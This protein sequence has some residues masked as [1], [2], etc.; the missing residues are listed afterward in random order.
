MI[1]DIFKRKKRTRFIPLP[2]DAQGTRMTM[3]VNPDAINAFTPDYKGRDLTH[4]AV[5]GNIYAIDLPIEQ[6]IIKINN[7]E[8]EIQ[9]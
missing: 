6:F 3:Y 7:Y 1:L 5:N 2:I 4:I 9:D 8:Q